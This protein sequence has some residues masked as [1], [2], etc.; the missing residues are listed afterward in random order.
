[1]Y[2]KEIKYALTGVTA[3]YHGTTLDPPYLIEYSTGQGHAFL[4]LVQID[5]LL[6][7]GSTTVDVFNMSSKQIQME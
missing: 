4:N 3:T 6:R 7:N 1:M 2:G 5:F